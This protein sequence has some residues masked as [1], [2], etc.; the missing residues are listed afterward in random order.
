[1]TYKARG[2]PNF[3]TEGEFLIGS[4]RFHKLLVHLMDS[5]DEVCSSI[6]NDTVC[7][8]STCCSLSNRLLW[9]QMA[10]K[11]PVCLQFEIV[12]SYKC[13]LTAIK[14]TS[15]P[16]TGVSIENTQSHSTSF[17]HSLFKTSC[18]YKLACFYED[19][20]GKCT[21]F[22]KERPKRN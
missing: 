9:S 7:Q 8:Q 21:S 22:L 1:M 18:K 10:I 14:K 6:D 5:F 16:G 2:G 19:L 11:F 15:K 13:K 3:S 12:I 4:Y 17:D 20:F